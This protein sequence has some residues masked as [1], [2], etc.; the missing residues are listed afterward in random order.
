MEVYAV[1]G[2]QASLPSKNRIYVMR[3]ANLHQTMYDDDPENVGL[4]AEFNEGNPIIVHR[5]IPIKG[6]INRIRSM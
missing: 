6:G 5:S 3:M 1:A 4:E 2:S